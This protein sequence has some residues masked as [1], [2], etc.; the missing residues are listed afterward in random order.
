MRR[1]QAL[2]ARAAALA[3]ARKRAQTQVEQARAAI[4]KDKMAAQAGLQ[5]ETQRLAAEIIRI[6]LRPG[7][8]QLPA[9]GGR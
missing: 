6:V 5:Q 1:Q 8:G 4:E 2:Q 9:G 7:L 3:E